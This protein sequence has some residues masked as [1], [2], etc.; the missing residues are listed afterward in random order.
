LASPPLIPKRVKN[1]ISCLATS[2]LAEPT[3]KNK[4]QCSDIGV[5]AADDASHSIEKP[6]QNHRSYMYDEID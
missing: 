3:P 2:I 1:A 4:I 6:G 5:P